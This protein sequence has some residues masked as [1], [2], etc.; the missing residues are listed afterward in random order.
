MQSAENDS[1]F[2]RSAPRPPRGLNGENQSAI[3]FRQK[4]SFFTRFLAF[5]G[6]S[7]NPDHEKSMGGEQKMMC[8]LRTHL[9]S[10]RPICHTRYNS[11][12]ILR[13]TWGVSSVL[14]FIHAALKC[15]QRAKKWSLL[16][17]DHL[18]SFFHEKLL[19]QPFLAVF[20]Q[21]R[22]II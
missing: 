13:F 19:F 10:Y 8:S 3:G 22:V 15:L 5:L 12:P 17:T 7:G 18:S 2:W 21:L 9:K 1:H 20:Q 14:L 16:V 6:P 4:E 11:R